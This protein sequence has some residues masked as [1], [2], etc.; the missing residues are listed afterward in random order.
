MPS[1]QR[2]YHL[3]ETDAKLTA[4]IR[5][6]LAEAREIL[7]SPLPDTFLGRKSFEPFSHED[8]EDDPTACPPARRG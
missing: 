8:K 6:A 7:K 5:Q 4:Q 3:L 1:R 2:I